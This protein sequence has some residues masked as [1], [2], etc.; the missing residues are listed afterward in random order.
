MSRARTHMMVR[1]TWMVPWVVFIGQMLFITNRVAY[2]GTP[3]VAA[4]SCAE[5]LPYKPE[6]FLAKFLFVSDEVDPYAV[7]ATF[8][9]VFGM[10]LPHVIT[11][12]SKTSYYDAMPCEWYA[13]VHVMTIDE[14]NLEN[15]AKA[16]LS[17]G[18]LPQPLLFGDS[19]E[20]L[21]SGLATKSL[22]ADGWHGGVLPGE[23]VAWG[24]KKGR[25]SISF[26]P[27]GK[28]FPNGTDCVSHVIVN[29]R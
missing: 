15:G 26:I 22:E 20:C 17:V 23:T 25:A 18:E 13:R 8:Q 12:D 9:H 14:P 27:V 24:Y 3:T 5:Q 28:V 10:R 11:K 6:E 16:Y 19:K 2:G 4:T 21:S 1:L 7:P 29:Y